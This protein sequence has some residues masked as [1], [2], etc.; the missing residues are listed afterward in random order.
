MRYQREWEKIDENSERLRVPR[1][2]IV[3]SYIIPAM[4]NGASVHQIF[5]SD[6]YYDWVL[7]E[8]KN[9]KSKI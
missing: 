5:I 3:R 4:G 1:G 9:E 7:E 6:E 8:A 2:W